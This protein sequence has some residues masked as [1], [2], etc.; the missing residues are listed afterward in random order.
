MP[1]SRGS[2]GAATAVNDFYELAIKMF[3]KKEY[4]WFYANRLAVEGK[5]KEAVEYYRL[6]PRGNATLLRRS[7]V[8]ELVLLAGLVVAISILT[9][10]EPPLARR[11]RRGECDV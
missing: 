10:V 7:A 11:C 5:S 2:P 8:G 1:A 4:A 9:D 3:G 6:V